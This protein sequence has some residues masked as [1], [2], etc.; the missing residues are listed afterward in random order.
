MS[1][2]GGG[3]EVSGGGGGNAAKIRVRCAINKDKPKDVNPIIHR[4]II[5]MCLI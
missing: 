3:G 2:L 4:P 5:V 1:A